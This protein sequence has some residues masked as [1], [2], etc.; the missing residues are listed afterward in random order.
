MRQDIIFF[1][2]RKISSCDQAVGQQRHLMK[3]FLLFLSFFLPKF[4]YLVLSITLNG[5]FVPLHLTDREEGAGG[6]TDKQF[7]IHSFLDEE[8]VRQ[9]KIS[10][11]IETW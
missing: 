9:M 7:I 1:P 11:L 6:N 8:S 2:S 10:H 3:P 4:C 5:C